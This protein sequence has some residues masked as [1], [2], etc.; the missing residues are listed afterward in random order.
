LRS[1]ALLGQR[2][3]PK[4]LDHGGA[5][6]AFAGRV[7]GVQASVVELLFPPV[8]RPVDR[9]AVDIAATLDNEGSSRHIVHVNGRCKVS[10]PSHSK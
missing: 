3:L 5:L 1:G 7:D 9:S 2:S 8:L 6:I 4:Q 10:F